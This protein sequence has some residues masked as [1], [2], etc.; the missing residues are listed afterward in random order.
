MPE[1]PVL[2]PAAPR[3][4]MLVMAS[5]WVC[6]LANEHAERARG[7]DGKA[8]LNSELEAEAVDFLA[9]TR[10]TTLAGLAAKAV[11]ATRRNDPLTGNL[12]P[13]ERIVFSLLRDLLALGKQ[14]TTSDDPALACA[15]DYFEAWD[16]VNANAPEPGT[17]EHDALVAA[18]DEASGRC[19][20]TKPGTIAGCLALVEVLISREAGCALNEETRVAV[21]TLRD[22]LAGLVSA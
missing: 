9:R 3:D 10:A 22:G 15:R 20:R 4:D 13:D 17:P 16:R 18:W 14:P 5:G 12:S 11:A 2:P 8:A 7:D 21:D 1:K 19:Y 6:R